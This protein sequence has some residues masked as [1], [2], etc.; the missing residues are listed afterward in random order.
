M[1]GYTFTD[2]VIWNAEGLLTHISYVLEMDYPVGDQDVVTNFGTPGH[3]GILASASA[4]PMYICFLSSLWAEA[5]AHLQ[6]YTKRDE[7]SQDE[8]IKM[9]VPFEKHIADDREEFAYADILVEE[10]NKLFHDLEGIS[11]AAANNTNVS[12]YAAIFD[13]LDVQQFLSMVPHVEIYTFGMSQTI[14]SLLDAY[15]KTAFPTTTL[16]ESTRAFTI[17]DTYVTDYKGATITIPTT[18]VGSELVAVVCRNSQCK[19]ETIDHDRKPEC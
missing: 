2:Y 12:N 19:T 1:N 9:I 6:Q 13:N 7:P 8:K 17:I 5:L 16:F 18:I 10:T 4:V 15:S 3:S 11:G 14:Q